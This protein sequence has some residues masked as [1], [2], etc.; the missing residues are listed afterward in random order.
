MRLSVSAVQMV[1]MSSSLGL[2]LGSMS[3]KGTQDPSCVLSFWE[4]EDSSHHPSA[5]MT[6]LL[7]PGSSASRISP[8]SWKRG[9]I[10]SVTGITGMFFTSWHLSRE[11]L[12]WAYASSQGPLHT[13]VL[14]CAFCYMVLTLAKPTPRMPASPCPEPP[15][16]P[17]WSL[18]ST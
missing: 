4:S 12:C 3:D 18:D 5:S 8:C 2:C 10:A 15:S 6:V 7:W 17:I 11:I 14:R 1:V 9:I 16:S 13:S